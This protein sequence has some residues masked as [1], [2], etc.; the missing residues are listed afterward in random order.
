MHRAKLRA[1]GPPDARSARRRAQ[2][3]GPSGRPEAVPVQQAVA[4]GR[5]ATAARRAEIVSA[6]HAHR[7]IPT[8]VSLRGAT[9]GRPGEGSSPDE[10]GGRSTPTKEGRTTPHGTA[11]TA[12]P[13]RSRRPLRPPDP[14]VEPEDAPIHL[15]RT[16]RHL[17]HR[18]PEDAPPDPQGAGAPPR[19]DPEGRQRPLR[20][21]QAPAQG[22]GPVGGRA[23]RRV[24]CHRA[25]AGRHADQLRRPSRSRSAGSGT[26]SRARRKATSRTIPRRKSCS[27]SG[28]A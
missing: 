14:P 12:G 1:A 15:R 10:R 9:R 4:T 27:S 2:E 8:R 24:L 3:A 21:H 22:R 20:L 25:L 5:P 18:P 17:H 26:S 13:A 23:T 19:R 28:S 7:R 11:P 6:H 16:F